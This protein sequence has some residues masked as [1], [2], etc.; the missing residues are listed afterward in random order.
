MG[1]SWALQGSFDG[2]VVFIYYK[3]NYIYVFNTYKGSG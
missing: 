2:R 1:E 3:F